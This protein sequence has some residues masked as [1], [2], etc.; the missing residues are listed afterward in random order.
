MGNMQENQTKKA[1]S[2]RLDPKLHAAAKGKAG[3]EGIT[4]ERLV[5]EALTLRVSR[6][7]PKKAKVAA[8]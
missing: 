8:K 3:T 5:E 7:G 1:Y 4:L 2:I 6:L